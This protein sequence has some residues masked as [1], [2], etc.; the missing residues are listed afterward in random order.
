MQLQKAVENIGLS[1]NE[2]RVYLAALELGETHYSALAE[3]AGLKRATLYYDV[4]PSLM[5]KGL[6]TQKV[7]GKRR[8]LIAE[9]IQDYVEEKKKQLIEVE[10]EIPYLRTLLSSASVKPT[11]LLFEGIEGIKKVWQDHLKQSGE[12]LEFIGIEKINPELQKYVKEHYIWKR[13]EKKILLKMLISGPTIAGIFKVKSDP[14]EM[15][16]VKHIDGA[17]FPIPLGCDIYGDSVSIT[18]HREDSEPVGLI[19]RSKE[20]AT[21]MRSLF[22]FIWDKAKTSLKS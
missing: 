10:K 16:A 11:V 21:T 3:K 18:L 1:G 20:I 4:L 22:N 14:Y 15:R 2:S 5:K 8:Y 7:R 12:I 6:I 13:A 9:D 19:I 17:L